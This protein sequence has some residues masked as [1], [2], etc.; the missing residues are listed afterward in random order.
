MADVSALA[1]RLFGAAD[2]NARLELLGARE[3]HPRAA[4][5]VLDACQGWPYVR[6]VL[7]R[8]IAGPRPTLVYGDYDVDGSFAAFMLFRYLRSHSVPGNVFLPSRFKHGY[9]LDQTVIEQAVA[10]GY[11]TLLALDCG[12]ANAAEIATAIAGGMDAAIIDHHSP[13]AEAPDAP[14]LNPHTDQAL[15]PLCTAG[16]VYEVLL[17]LSAGGGNALEGDELEL[18]GLATIADIVPLEPHNWLLA[19]E[20]LECL[21]QT[22]NPG[23]AEL[24]KVSRLH[25]LDRLTSQQASFQLVP[26]LNAAG[27]MRSARLVLDLLGAP[28]APSAR[29]AAL[30]LDRLNELRKQEA[31]AV[32]RK[33]V[34]QGAEFTQEQALALYAPDWH[35][36]VLGIVAAR[37][38]EQLGKP[39]II[40]CDAPGQPEL[41]TG[42]AR[43]TGG[44]NLIDALQNTGSGAHSF[45]GHAQAAGVKVERRRL[46]AFRELWSAAVGTVNAGA[47][48]PPPEVF[49]DVALHELTSQ[50]EH[51][52]WRLAPFGPGYRAPRCILR[53]VKVARVN[54]MGRDKTHLS[55][56]V[57]D[58][59]R[60]VRIAAFN[61]SHLFNRLRE[62]TALSPL[63]EIDADNWNN[64]NT[65]TLRLLAVD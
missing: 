49:P 2:V 3:A 13:K 61:Q 54:Y 36:G 8:A 46:A 47:P 45:G 10:Q 44:I 6:Q 39:A 55:L 58:G 43:T 59:A 27:R 35:A 63:V 22:S 24:I 9:G 7:E 33:A 30:E 57:S 17:A 40:L 11:T 48:Q 15:P 16:L 19:H 62:G 53:N 5:G 37:V 38:A 42:S 26:R 65:I 50:F 14:L 23:L 1:L 20:A 60:E 64:A 4:S 41:L 25:G 31:E 56:V 34:L 51:D 52:M 28:D 29:Q 12:T 32:F 21:P 18:A